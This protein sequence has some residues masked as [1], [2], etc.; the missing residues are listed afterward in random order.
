MTRIGLEYFGL[1]N[2]KVRQLIEMLPNANKCE[3]YRPVYIKP[4]QQQQQ[5]Q[6]QQQ[7]DM[8][9]TSASEEEEFSVRP[10]RSKRRSSQLTYPDEE[11][12]PTKKPKRGLIDLLNK[13]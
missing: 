9:S 13:I 8:Q 2:A 4:P 5:Q 1:S 6:Q 10:R 7:V 11:E 3:N 12:I